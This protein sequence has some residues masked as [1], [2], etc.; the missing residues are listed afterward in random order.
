MEKFKKLKTLIENIL[1][2]QKMQKSLHTRYNITNSTVVIIKIDETNCR[3]N[4]KIDKT[5]S[6]D[7]IWPVIENVYQ[8]SN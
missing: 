2:C 6:S 5:Y 8:F 1:A 4:W 3:S 7:I